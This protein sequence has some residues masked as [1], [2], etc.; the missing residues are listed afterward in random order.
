MFAV[1]DF[2]TI[3]KYH[4]TGSGVNLF[5]NYSEN[6]MKNRTGKTYLEIN[7]SN[8]EIHELTVAIQSSIFNQSGK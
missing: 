3:N 6:N 7:S 5:Y 1:A 2:A 4:A 8:S